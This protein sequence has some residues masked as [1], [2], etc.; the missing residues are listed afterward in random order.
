MKRPSWT[1]PTIKKHITTACAA[2]LLLFTLS[3]SAELITFDT[4]GD[5]DPI[6]AGY[7]RLQWDN[8]STLDA[9][10]EGTSGYLAGM[11]SKRNVAYNRYGSPARI[12][13]GLNGS[14]TPLTAYVTAA[15]NDNLQ[16]QV[17]GY[18]RGRR[19]F[20]RTYKLSATKPTIIKFGLRVDELYFTSSGGT[21]H[22]YGGGGTHFA[23]D[24]LQVTSVNPGAPVPTVVPEFSSKNP[25]AAD[26]STVSE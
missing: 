4:L 24:N 6:P 21:N 17:E 26:S 3:A 11:K 5:G 16:L 10:T 9:V 14:F 25:G 19:V 12:Y 8:F 20:S 18:L 15:W 23:M 7:S 13:V 2:G 1:Y 22:G